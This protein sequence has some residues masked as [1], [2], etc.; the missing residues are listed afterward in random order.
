MFA[1]PEVEIVAMREAAAHGDV[2]HAKEVRRR[3]H[4]NR[5]VDYEADFEQ[6]RAAALAAIEDAMVPYRAGEDALE[7]RG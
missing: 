5:G 4:A 3:W 2:E 7:A 1:A 6:R